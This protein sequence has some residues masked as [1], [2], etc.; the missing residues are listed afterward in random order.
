VAP[1]NSL[2]DADW[3]RAANRYFDDLMER[4]ILGTGLPSEAPPRS[5]DL[6][7]D[8]GGRVIGRV[9]SVVHDSVTVDLLLPD[10]S[11]EA[12]TPHIVD[13]TRR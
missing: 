1:P 10:L 7:R 5:G 8:A 12:D 11:E 9:A 13:E 4:L 3:F 2:P 6:V